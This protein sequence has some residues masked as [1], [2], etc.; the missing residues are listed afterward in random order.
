MV[1]EIKRERIRTATQAG[2]GVGPTNRFDDQFPAQNSNH[3]ATLRP[4]RKQR[5][6]RTRRSADT[7]TNRWPTANIASRAVAPIKANHPARAVNRSPTLFDFQSAC[8]RLA[9]RSPQALR[10][11]WK[12][13]GHWNLDS[14]VNAASS[15]QTKRAMRLQLCATRSTRFDMLVE[16][17]VRTGVELPVNVSR[18]EISFT[19]FFWIACRHLDTGNSLVDKL[20][21]HHLARAKQSGS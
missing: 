20:L 5:S 4:R 18:N 10:P 16:Q 13:G 9:C 11:F 2:P 17:G 3:Y 12:T 19:D 21:P 1:S 14:S 7:A 6:T 15:S 8:E